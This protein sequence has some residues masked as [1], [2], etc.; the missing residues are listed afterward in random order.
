VTGG[1]RKGI[2][3]VYSTDTRPCE[4]LARHCTEADLLI[5]EGMYGDEEKRP[6]ALKNHHMLFAEAAEIARGA[7]AGGLLLTHFS[8][9]MEDPEAYLPEARR[10]FEKTW[11]AKDGQTVTMRY[12]EKEEKAWTSLY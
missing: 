11:A 5:L 10:I 4:T 9:S 12:P 6:Q 8:T 2:T 3:L 7:G 1:A